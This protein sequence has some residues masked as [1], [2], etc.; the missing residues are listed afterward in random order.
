MA[1]SARRAHA[2]RVPQR[3]LL[4]DHPA[5]GDAEDV[6]PSGAALPGRDS[7]RVE[8]GN[9]VLCHFSHPEEA[10]P[11]ARVT[12]PAVVEGDDEEVLGE[13]LGQRAPAARGDCPCP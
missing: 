3:E 1:P 9:G 5:H 11:R 10:Q 6:G 2:L 4:R 7:H 8:H 13:L 12:G